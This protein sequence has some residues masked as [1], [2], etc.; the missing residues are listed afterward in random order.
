[1]RTSKIKANKFLRHQQVQNSKTGDSHTSISTCLEFSQMILWRQ[2]LS[3][4]R[5]PTFITMPHRE[6]YIDVPPMGYSSVA[7]QLE[8]QVKSSKKLTTALVELTNPIWS[9]ETRSKEWAT[10]SLKCFPT[11]LRCHACQ[12]HEDIIHQAPGYLRAAKAT[13]PFEMWGMDIIGPISPPPSPHAISKGHWF[14]HALTHY[15]SKWAKTI[16]L[17]EIKAPDM[18]KY[19]KYCAIYCFGVPRRIIRD[20]GRQFVG[21]TFQRL[22]N[23]F[24]IQSVLNSIL[25]ARQQSLEA[26][27]KMIGKFLK[28]FV[29]WS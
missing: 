17:R 7:S 12:V 27:N 13:W 29:S 15:F 6:H 9:S 28:K 18:V 20:N 26:F 4:G 10:T 3:K 22:Y 14:I 2:P 11:P 24:W 19:V 25:S 16:P 5:P 21:Q 8:K 23:K 1:M